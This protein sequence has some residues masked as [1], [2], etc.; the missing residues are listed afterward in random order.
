MT[1]LSESWQATSPATFAL[2]EKMTREAM[3][4]ELWDPVALTILSVPGFVIFGVLALL[5]YLVGHRRQRRRDRFAT[6]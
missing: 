5:F 4:K 3:V 2:A 6:I 1:P